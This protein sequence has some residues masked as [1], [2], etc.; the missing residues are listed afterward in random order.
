MP[1]ANR[2]A[3]LKNWIAD[4][5]EVSPSEVLPVENAIAFPHVYVAFEYTGPNDR[6][7]LGEAGGK[8]PQRGANATASDAAVAYVDNQGQKYLVLIEWKYTEKYQNH[9]LSADLRGTR[10]HRYGNLVL[11]PTGPIR[12]DLGL[13]LENFLYEPFYQFLRQQIL[14]WQIEA[15]PSSGFDKVSVL[16]LSPR[17][18]KALHQLT[19]PDVGAAL[20][21]IDGVYV[22]D[23]FEAYSACLT[24]PDRFIQRHIED[25]FNVLTESPNS[26]AWYPELKSRYPSLCP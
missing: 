17:A 2:P 15:E 10:Q 11:S 20:R 5:L 9:K 8:K 19:A 4:V 26:N 7:Y 25:S 24:Q 18:N 6:D 13:K 23:A 1:L 22:E 12:S 3:L 14:A 21:E 16:H